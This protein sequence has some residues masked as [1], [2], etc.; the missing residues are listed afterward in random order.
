MNKKLIAGLI[1]L[2]MV[3]GAGAYLGGMTQATGS[4]QPA[5]SATPAVGRS[6]PQA[7]PHPSSPPHLQL[8]AAQGDAS[9]LTPGRW[10][11]CYTYTNG[12]YESTPSPRYI[13][14]VPGGANIQVAAIAPPASVTRIAYY[15]SQAANVVSQLRRYSVRSGGD[16]IVS[17]PGTGPVAP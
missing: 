7:L 1:G 9:A 15:V 16:V 5:P 17:G 12:A 8:V 3:A 4:R 14:T 2:P 13:L 6:A 11:V 10:A